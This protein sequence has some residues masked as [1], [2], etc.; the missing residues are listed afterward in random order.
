M[1][2]RMRKPRRRA[3]GCSP[4]RR[5]EPGGPGRWGR[6]GR[7][8]RTRRPTAATC[9]GPR[10]PC[11]T[12]CAEGGGRRRG[13]RGRAGRRL[14]WRLRGGRSHRDGSVV[15]YHL[16]RPSASSGPRRSRRGAPADRDLRARRRPGGRRLRRR[17]P[18]A[19][20]AA[21]HDRHRQPLLADEARQPLGLQGDRQAARC[22]VEVTVT[23]DQAARQRRHRPGGP[24]RG[25]REG[26]PVE[27]TDDWYAQDREGNVWYLGEQTAEY[28]NG[29]V[30]TRAGSFEAG[31]GRREGGDHHAGQPASGHGL[32]PGVLQ[33]R[34]RGQGRACSAS[35]TR[36]RCPRA[37]SGTR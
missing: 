29:K 34:G 12:G 27:L 14:R 22:E 21:L 26:E 19:R 32:P 6:R 4:W 35:T 37:T 24:R 2:D 20:G 15:E 5:A 10:R 11:R 8:G 7:R 18:G 9:A 36:P 33:G 31:E 3:E 23:Q 25:D 13:H 30:K 1:T 17:P 28:E 16:D